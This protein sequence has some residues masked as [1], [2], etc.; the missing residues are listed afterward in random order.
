MNL[1]GTV[2]KRALLYSGSPL[3]KAEEKSLYQRPGNWAF[4]GGKEIPVSGKS[5]A[6]ML[7]NFHPS[8]K[9]DRLHRG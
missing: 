9:D 3:E 7:L 5:E 6:R 4:V 2:L 1:S 8:A